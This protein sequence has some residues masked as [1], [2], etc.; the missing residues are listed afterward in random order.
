MKKILHFLNNYLEETICV[1]LMSV[2]TVVIFVQVVMRYVAQNSLSWSEELARYCFIWLIYIGVAYG[3]KLMKHIKID[4]A[5]YLFP[6]KARPYIV[7]LGELLVLLFAVYI[8]VTGVELTYKQHL[9][10]KVSPALGLPLAYINAAPVVGFGLVII[11]QIQAIWHLAGRLGL[12]QED[13]T[14]EKNTGKGGEN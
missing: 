10:G 13:G 6:K 3:C 2:M 9:F 1:F 12:P 7:I 4:A 8:V 5:L 11:R 14:E